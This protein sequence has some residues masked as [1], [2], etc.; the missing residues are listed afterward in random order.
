[1][2]NKAQRRLFYG[3]EVKAPWPDSFP[4]GRL[5]KPQ[6]RHITIAFLGNVEQS[7]I[8]S[9]I[10]QAPTPHFKISPVGIFIAPLF[11]PLEN[12]RVVAWKGTLSED[13]LTPYHDTLT[14]FLKTLGFTFSNRKLLNHTSLARSPFK[15]NEWTQAFVPLP[16]IAGDLHLYESLGNLTYQPIWTHPIAPPFEEFEH[17]ADIAFRV[18]GKNVQQ[19]YIHAQ[20]ALAFEYSELLPFLDLQST[21]NTLDDVIIKLN[22]LITRSDQKI[23]TPFKA[24]SFHGDLIDED[25]LTW[26]MIVD[27]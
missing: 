27:V 24:V 23:G 25:V 19:L 21:V 11:L 20:F 13:S 22:E 6:H 17:V 16:F 18:R 26:E 14:S 1:M 9:L 2:S 4:E 3:F 5:I 8:H 10:Q 7:M 15:Q 12:P